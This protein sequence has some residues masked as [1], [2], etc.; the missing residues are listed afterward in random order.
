MNREIK[1]FQLIFIFLLTVNNVS[2]DQVYQVKRVD[3]MPVIDGSSADD[4]WLNIQELEV[5]D[6]VANH[7]LYFSAVHDGDNIAIKV[8]FPDP[9]QNLEH[10]TLI[11]DELDSM[12]KMG[13]TREDTLVLKWAMSPLHRDL[14]LNSNTP[15]QADIW[16]WKAF[17]TDPVGYADD[18]LQIYSKIPKKK[19]QRLRSKDGSLFFLQ[20]RGDN[21]TSAYQTEILIEKKQLEQAKFSHRQ[22]QGSR[23][24]IKAKGGWNENEWI[25][26]FLRKLDT[27]HNDDIQLIPGETVLL[28]LSRFEIAGRKRNNTLQQPLYGSGDVGELIKLQLEK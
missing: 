27:K 22:P 8:R 7:E 9:T 24:D 23:A 19:A 26:E 14:T 12:Y 1:M 6:V 15:Y 20:R 16:F 5:N 13:P 28:G 21:G 4:V 10:K 17:R 3:S 11:W 18:K 25:V 2:A